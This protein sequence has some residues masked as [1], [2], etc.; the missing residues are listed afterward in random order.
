[1]S[2]IISIETAHPSSIMPNL[3]LVRVTTDDG[4]VGHGETY[5]TPGAVAALV[6][7]WMA[8]RLLGADALAVESHWRFLYERSR[9]FG[10]PGAE[11]RALSAVDVALW[12]ILGQACGQPIRR[13]LGGPVREN[14][15]IYNT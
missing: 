10:Q 4:L 9:S 14:I 11:M 6:H 8:E 1:M 5:Y 15:R 7:E 13:L 2:K 12:D 3:L